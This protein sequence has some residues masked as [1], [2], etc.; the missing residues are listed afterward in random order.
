LTQPQ[1][2]WVVV[3]GGVPYER[4][5]AILRVLTNSPA[6]LVGECDRQLSV[7]AR[8]YDWP[9][10][11]TCAHVNSQARAILPIVNLNL[12]EVLTMT[13]G[14]IWLVTAIVLGVMVGIWL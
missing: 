3:V 14:L 1:I 7:A 8:W 13:P 9:V 4:L 12:S 2:G 11:N 6:I 10:C 5:R